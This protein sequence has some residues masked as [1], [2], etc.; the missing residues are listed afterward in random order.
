[1]ILRYRL[2][3]F[4]AILLTPA[5][6][7]AQSGD[8]LTRIWTGVQQAQT[9]FTTGCG[10]VTETR[11][12]KLMVKPMVLRGKFCAEGTDRFMLEYAEPNPMRIRFNGSYLNITT[13]RKTN[14]I[15]VDKGV[16]HAQSE[17][18]GENSIDNLKKSFTITAQESNQ[19]FEMR[20][21]PR[22]ESLRHRL[23]Y[24]IVKLNKHNFFLRS[25]EVDGKTGVNS[26]FIFD[27]TSV[28][29]ALPVDTFEV[30]KT[31]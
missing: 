27:L 10:S 11:T 18:G 20:L 8:L 7:A 29:I 12:S 23:N 21:I 16:R 1:M 9:K 15:N 24:L 22:S 31:K 4:L 30:I 13:K 6:L 28:N 3:W 26:V 5:V 2:G 25:L 17:F 19:Y 14:I